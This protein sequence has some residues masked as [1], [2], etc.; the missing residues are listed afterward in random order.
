MHL[1]HY[2]ATSFACFSQYFRGW[3]SWFASHVKSAA[4]ITLHAAGKHEVLDLL[5]EGFRDSY[6]MATERFFMNI[7]DKGLPDFPFQP[8]VVFPSRISLA[9]INQPKMTVANHVLFHHY[10]SPDYFLRVERLCRYHQV[11]SA[12]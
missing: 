2:Q 1:M 5:L 9:Y 11:H 4:C 10:Y 8:T 3:R 6:S 12:V 7:G